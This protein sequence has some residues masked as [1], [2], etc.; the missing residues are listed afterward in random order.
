M[1]ELRMDFADWSGDGDAN[2]CERKITIIIRAGRKLR[3]GG[4]GEGANMTNGARRIPLA[5]GD[6][7]SVVSDR[8]YSPRSSAMFFRYNRC[9]QCLVAFKKKKKTWP[10]KLRPRPPM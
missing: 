6:G 7:G 4:G 10:K 3:G 8:I 1:I 9:K 2:N 5:A